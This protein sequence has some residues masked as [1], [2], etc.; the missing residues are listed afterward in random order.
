VTDRSI[1]GR[2]V[3]RLCVAPNPRN[4]APFSLGIY[5]PKTV[6]NIPGSTDATGQSADMRL[7]TPPAAP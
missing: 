2:F 3:G 1:A 5:N 4:D 6:I 7:S